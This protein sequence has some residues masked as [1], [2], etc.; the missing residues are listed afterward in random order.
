MSRLKFMMT[1][2]MGV[3]MGIIITIYFN[4]DNKGYL[5]LDKDYTLENGSIIRK[6]TEIKIDKGMSEGFTRYKLYI[7][8]KHTSGEVKLYDKYNYVIPYWAK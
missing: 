7:N 6:R 1:F 5:M 8:I 3:T 2:V 4:F